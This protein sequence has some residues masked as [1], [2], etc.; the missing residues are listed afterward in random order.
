MFLFD[1]TLALIVAAMLARIFHRGRSDPLRRWAVPA[2]YVLAFAFGI[3]LLLAWGEPRVGGLP[4]SPGAF[5]LVPVLL[6]VLLATGW[7]PG[8]R[9]G[10]MPKTEWHGERSELGFSVAIFFSGAALLYAIILAL[11]YL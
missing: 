6:I 3:L 5:F 10:T 7:Q 9:P 1:L 2:A 4:V 8:Q 11:L